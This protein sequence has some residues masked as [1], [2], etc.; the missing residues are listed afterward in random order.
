MDGHTRGLVYCYGCG[1]MLILLLHFCYVSLL[2]PWHKDIINLVTGGGS[3]SDESRAFCVLLFILSIYALVLSLLLVK[4][5]KIYA[6][7]IL[8]INIL[9]A[10]FAVFKKGIPILWMVFLLVSSMVFIHELIQYDTLRK[11]GDW[12]K[13]PDTE[14]FS[15]AKMSFVWSILVFIL[16][17]MGI[18]SK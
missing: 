15:I 16:G 1:G 13:K 4:G 2:S 9:A 14:S 5:K 3:Q 11:I 10:S 8:L 7:L 17:V 18:A 6:A 12:L